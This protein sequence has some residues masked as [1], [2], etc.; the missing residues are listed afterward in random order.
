MLLVVGE[1]GHLAD[2]N[3][4]LKVYSEAQLINEFAD[5]GAPSSKP[6]IHVRERASAAVIHVEIFDRAATLG[7]GHLAVF[8][9]VSKDRLLASFNGPHELRQLE[10]EVDQNVGFR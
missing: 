7:V 3:G 8:L 2:L 10:S 5:G 6:Y 9:V 4:P 1:E